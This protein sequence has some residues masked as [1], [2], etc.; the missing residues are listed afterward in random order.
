MKA[1]K[2]W[3]RIQLNT[4]ILHRRKLRYKEGE[5]RYTE[6][7]NQL[8]AETGPDAI[9]VEI[10][11]QHIFLFSNTCNVLSFYNWQLLDNF[12]IFPFHLLDCILPL[13]ATQ[14]KMT[15]LTRQPLTY[16]RIA[17]M[18]IHRFSRISSISNAVN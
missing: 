5:V 14:T 1:R 3:K 10:G 17:L 6:S 7:H 12:S 11:G 2:L 13:G 16:L 15:P 9:S 18:F 8:T 4:L